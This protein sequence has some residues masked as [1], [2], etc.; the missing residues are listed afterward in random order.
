MID[1][2]TELLAGTDFTYELHLLPWPRVM[3]RAESEANQLIITL[4]RSEEREN[5][6]HWVGPIAEVNHALYGLDTMAVVPQTLEQARD[7]IVATV[8]DDVASDYLERNGFTNLVR[9][10]NHLRGLELLTRGRVDLYPGNTSLIDYQCVQLPRG[11]TQLQLVMPLTDLE[12]ELYFALSLATDESVV[13]VVRERFNALVANGRL[14]EL[15]QLFL[16]TY[17]N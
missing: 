2:A 16:E 12:Q 8:L 13:N 1:F 3:R 11:C 7:F 5:R 17:Q 4:I 10:S 15:R 9:T 14:E 6:V